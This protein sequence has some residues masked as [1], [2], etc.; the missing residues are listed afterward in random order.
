MIEILEKTGFKH[1][2]H[3]PS[4]SRVMLNNK[5]VSLARQ[6]DNF[7]FAVENKEKVDQELKLLKNEGVCIDYVDQ[8]KFNRLD[9]D[10]RRNV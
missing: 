10:E 7:G 2:T 8:P 1:A 9:V 5:E 4:M 3:E 6:V